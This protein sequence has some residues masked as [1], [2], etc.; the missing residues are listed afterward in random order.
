MC[1]EPTLLNALKLSQAAGFSIPTEAS[2]VHRATS[3]ELKPTVKLK[4]LGKVAA[5]PSRELLK[6]IGSSR[7]V[8]A[9][10]IKAPFNRWS[11]VPT[12]FV[13]R[14]K[15]HCSDECLLFRRS[16]TLKHLHLK[17]LEL[18]GAD[19]ISSVPKALYSL[20]ADELDLTSE[21]AWPLALINSLVVSC[22][23]SELSYQGQGSHIEF[24]SEAVLLKKISVRHAVIHLPLEL[25]PNL[26]AFE[27]N[28][29][30]SCNHLGGNDI[31]LV[32]PASL[33][34][35]RIKESDPDICC[36]VQ[37]LPDR[38]QFLQLEAEDEFG[39]RIE[40]LP[41]DLKVVIVPEMDCSNV[42]MPTGLKILHCRTPPAGDQ[43]QA[44]TG[45]QRLHITLH[46]TDRTSQ[47]DAKNLCDNLL[48][49]S[50]AVVQN[51]DCLPRS[52]QSLTAYEIISE[53][54]HLNLPDQLQTLELSTWCS[55][56]SP[57]PQCL[58]RLVLGHAIDTD[59]VRRNQVFYNDR[60]FLG[61]LPP[62]LELLE[63]DR[64]SKIAMEHWQQDEHSLPFQGPLGPLPSSLKAL[65]LRAQYD[66]EL[67]PLP[68]QLE[69]LEIGRHYRYSFDRP[70]TCTVL[71][72]KH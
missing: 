54:L 60:R 28:N 18:V 46:D 47:L 59:D 5:E 21:G 71:R 38:L 2:A 55:D 12:Q 23:A 63:V 35:L 25:P 57:L 52:L 27:L 33:E 9:V 40:Q 56:L 22:K 53:K 65:Y 36:N 6:S 43:L 24:P 67:Q 58:K 10:E 41:I 31:E 44:M 64:C 20:R 17:R 42:S 14:L 32:L 51:A 68:A 72:I 19:D 70:E 37:S 39:C 30:G 16:G 8:V 66:V 11:Q 62:C 48:R 49:L 45:L 4:L 29:V 15:L 7:R 3:N 69:L 34:L 13:K 1:R 61:P 26:E 50:C